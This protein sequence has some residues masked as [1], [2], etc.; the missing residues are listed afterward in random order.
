MAWWEYL[1]VGINDGSR[2]PQEW[3]P[4]VQERF[5]SLGQEGWELV[6]VSHSSATAY[7]KRVRPET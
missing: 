4:L 6:S 1:V 5:N 3:R 7:F 2:S